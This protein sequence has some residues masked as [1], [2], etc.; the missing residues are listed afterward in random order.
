[1]TDTLY[2]PTI[3]WAVIGEYSDPVGEIT[4]AVFFNRADAH[5]WAWGENDK[6]QADF[7]RVCD[8]SVEQHVGQEG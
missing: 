6:L 2:N 7:Y 8:M 5:L 4:E 3:V 1:M